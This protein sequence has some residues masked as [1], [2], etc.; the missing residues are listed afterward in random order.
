MS[1]VA[2]AGNLA[3]DVVDGGPPTPGGC[4]FF[5]ADAFRRLRRDGQVLTRF[6]SED[7]ELFRPLLGR[8]GSSVT[9]LPAETTS[10]FSIDY[11]G[12]ERR[13]GVTAIG[14]RWRP[15]DAAALGP[16]VEWV[17]VAPLLRSDF[18]PETLTALAAGR[19]LSLDGQGLVRVPSVGPLAFDAAFDPAVL[20]PVTALKLSEEEARILAGGAFEAAAATRLGIPEVLVTLGSHG[21]VVFAGGRETFVPAAW[22]VLGVQTTG[23]GDLFMV[24]YAV[25]RVDGLDPVAAAQEAGRLVAELLEERKRGSRR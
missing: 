22:P 2:V 23:T 3:Q 5:A 19:Q 16:G 7:A 25:A 1:Q 17:H 21:A 9:L 10:G 20:A 11:D 13:M 15:E 18:P 8:L 4:A 12:E 14:E 6:R 24:A